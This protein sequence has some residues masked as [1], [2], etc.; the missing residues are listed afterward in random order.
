QSL[1]GSGAGAPEGVRWYTPE[2]RDAAARS[3]KPEFPA[4]GLWMTDEMREA[5]EEGWEDKLRVGEGPP[6]YF[7]H[8]ANFHIELWLDT[9]ARDGLWAGF[10]NLPPFLWFPVGSEVA[11]LLAA[12]RP[13][14]PTDLAR[15]REFVPLG[16]RIAAQRQSALGPIPGPAEGQD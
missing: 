5:A 11:S 7:D 10:Q 1:I 2:E 14:L 6:T 13:Y 3:R 15:P 16:R 12:L 9:R 4:S 8:A